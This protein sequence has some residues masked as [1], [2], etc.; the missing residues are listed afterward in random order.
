ML[1]LFAQVQTSQGKSS[2]PPKRLST[3][4]FGIGE[5]ISSGWC[6]VMASH[7]SCVTSNSD[8]TSPNRN[9]TSQG[10]R[11][12][13]E[14]GALTKM[15][16]ELAVVPSPSPNCEPH[17]HVPMA[18]LVPIVIGRPVMGGSV[19]SIPAEFH[20]TKLGGLNQDILARLEPAMGG[21]WTHKLV[22]PSGIGIMPVRN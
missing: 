5:T 11:R 17:N 14:P 1:L 2:F 10:V 13:D 8:L 7:H 19:G 20:K 9:F 4:D 21:L 16:G 22:H 18:Y 3:W 12:W 15:R 6:N